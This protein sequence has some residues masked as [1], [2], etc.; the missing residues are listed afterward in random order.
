M[1]TS[2][3]Q[4]E[5]ITLHLSLIDGIGPATIQTIIQSKPNNC[6]WDDF[7]SFSQQDWMHQCNLSPR[8]AS[9]LVGCLADTQQ[10]DKELKNIDRHNIS[11]ITSIDESYPSLLQ[12]IYL[13]PAVL[14]WQGSPLDES[15]KHIAVIGSRNANHY[16]K[17][18]INTLVPE[19]VAHNFV[20][21]SGGALGADSMAHRATLDA[22]GKT[23]VVLGSGLLQPY[24]ATNVRLFETIINQGGT[25]LSSFPLNRGALPGNFP[26]RN[27]IIAGLS[28]GCVVVQAA[29]KSG[30]RITAQFALDQ[31]REVFAV[32]GSVDDELSLGCHALIQDGAKL[33]NSV[34]D[35]LQEFGQ[36]TEKKGD[37]QTKIKDSVVPQTAI[38]NL[39]DVQVKIVQSCRQPCSIDDLMQRTN[40]PLPTL[41]GELFDLQLAG[42][43]QQDFTG[44]WIAQ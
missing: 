12:H 3:K 2:A 17:R 6:S 43:M 34:D 18:V 8:I 30:A 14:Y 44:M 23:V 37:Y 22:G 41:Q 9:K 20:I 25:V 1:K 39:S 27:R 24:P 31:G 32:P 33:V 21:V 7:Y 19:L 4:Q 15:H 13:P 26:A 5:L 36:V 28:Q 16:G 38:T 10:R 42:K 35:I 11:W 29:Q 40:L